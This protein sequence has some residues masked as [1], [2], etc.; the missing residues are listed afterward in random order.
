MTKEQYMELALSLAEATV[1]QTSPNPSVGAVV[2]KDGKILGLGSHLRQGEAHAEVHALSQAGS[3]AEGGEMFVTLEPCSHF[4]KTPPCADLIIEHKLKKIYVACLDPNPEVAGSGIAKLKQAGI[5]VDIGLGEAKA[6]ELNRKFFHFIKTG[7]PYVTMKAAMTLDGK[8]ATSVGDS[9]W[10]TAESARN[11]VHQERHIHDAILV[12]IGTVLQDDPHLTTRL[13]QGGKNPIRVILDTD[14][15]I[16][17]QANVLSDEAPTWIFC[18]INADCTKLEIA[19]PHVKI[20]R[21]ETEQINAEDVLRILGENKIQSLY[22][23]G[24]QSIHGTLV[25]KSLFNEC[26]WYIAPKML[27]GADAFQPVGGTAPLSM[28]G[29][30]ALTFTSVDKIGEDIKIVARPIKEDV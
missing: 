10:I 7:K 12:G 16:S 6:L 11:D 20:W 8:T 30:T 18:G 21:L 13:P 9:R 14:L 1:G 26:H 25:E 5:A 28:K 24:G 29:A 19:K 23:E 22:V 17:E 15:R 3:A 4:G 2:V 27:G